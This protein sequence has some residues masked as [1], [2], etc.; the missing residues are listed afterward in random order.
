MSYKKLTSVALTWLNEVR[1]GA[2]ESQPVA[3]GSNAMSSLINQLEF[4]NS[5]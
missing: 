3:D 2:V 5:K 1:Y 4:W